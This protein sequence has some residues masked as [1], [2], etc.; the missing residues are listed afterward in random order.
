M[1]RMGSSKT[2]LQNG[3][4]EMFAQLDA[5]AAIAAADGI[6]RVLG[7]AELLQLERKHFFFAVILGRRIQNHV[8]RCNH[9]LDVA[10]LCAMD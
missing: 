2:H 9:G 8:E 4:G 6:A 3:G 1:V 10:Q 5:C 7:Q